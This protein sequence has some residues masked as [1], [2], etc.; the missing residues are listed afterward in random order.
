MSEAKTEN[1]I[2]SFQLQA[3]PLAELGSAQ[4]KH[5]L[6]IFLK[7][8]ATK[9]VTYQKSSFIGL[10]NVNDNRKGGIYFCTG[11]LF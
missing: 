9:P 8:P 4:L 7:C 5:V 3:L 10:L 6:D 11:N 1:F 2:D